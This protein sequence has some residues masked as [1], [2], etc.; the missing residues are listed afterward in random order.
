MT[1]L[2]YYPE[3]DS[4]PILMRGSAC[5]ELVQVI[6]QEGLQRNCASM[7]DYLLKRLRGLQAK[8]NL[9]GDV[10]GSGLMLGV[11]LVRDRSSK[12]RRT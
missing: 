11:E 9:I 1:A 2:L 5:D 7:G 12:V 6:E 3:H 4:V 8:H 10:R